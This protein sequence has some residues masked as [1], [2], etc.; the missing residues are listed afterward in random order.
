MKCPYCR[1]MMTPVNHNNRGPR[2]PFCWYRVVIPEEG[3]AEEAEAI[4]EEI[5]PNDGINA[6]PGAREL[7]TEYGV[8]LSIVPGTGR[9]GRITKGDVM[10]FVED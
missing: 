9:D 10:P 1:E 2:C 6:T 7:A 5:E 4:E 3:L 8:D